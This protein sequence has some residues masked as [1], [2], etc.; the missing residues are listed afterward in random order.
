MVLGDA[1]EIEGLTGLIVA[2][3][4]SMRRDMGESCVT[5][6]ERVQTA[7]GLQAGA[8]PF[9]NTP[10]KNV[11][12]PES[13]GKIRL[14]FTKNTVVRSGAPLYPQWNAV[15]RDSYLGWMKSGSSWEFGIVGK[16]TSSSWD[17][18][19]RG[20][21][22]G[23]W[24][25]VIWRRSD[26]NGDP[27][28]ALKADMVANSGASDVYLYGESGGDMGLE[29]AINTD[30]EWSVLG[31]MANAQLQRVTSAE[32]ANSGNG[33]FM[34][35]ATAADPDFDAGSNHDGKPHAVLSNGDRNESQTFWVLGYQEK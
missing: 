30:E 11:I 21:Q 18:S 5:K 16:N 1:A 2:Q 15:G 26:R 6:L 28:V 33:G 10:M 8:G 35:Q 3:I 27:V 22:V 32:G 23:G 20:D 19:G 25:D 9:G 12:T 13:S 31:V 14:M 24:F 34:R 29:S 17:S 4:G 7:L